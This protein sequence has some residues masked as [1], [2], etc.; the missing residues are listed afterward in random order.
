MPRGVTSLQGRAPREDESETRR[1]KQA[2]MPMVSQSE[3]QFPSNVDSANLSLRNLASEGFSSG[4]EG[5]SRAVVTPKYST[6]RK[7]GRL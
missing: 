1:G 7:F 5:Q 6:T 3:S 2:H 4:I